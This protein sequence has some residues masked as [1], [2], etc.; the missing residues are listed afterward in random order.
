MPTY[1]C[2]KAGSSVPPARLEQWGAGDVCAEGRQAR[3]GGSNEACEGHRGCLGVKVMGGQGRGGPG[4]MAAAVAVISPSLAVAA[5]SKR[6][7]SPPAVITL[8]RSLPLPGCQG[9][10]PS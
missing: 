9:S 7:P 2:S 10:L 3:P 8:T 5:V 1:Q 4:V 6:A